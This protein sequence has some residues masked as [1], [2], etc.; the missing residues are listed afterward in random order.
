MRGSTA[1]AVASYPGE[2]KAAVIED[3]DRLLDSASFVGPIPALI[4][5]ATSAVIR[6]ARMA[7]RM[8]GVFRREVPEY[9]LAAVRE[10]IT[11]ALMHRDYSP[12]ACG[13]QVQVNL[14]TDRLEILNPGGL[15]GAVALA[16]LGSP[17][18]SSARNQHPRSL[19]RPG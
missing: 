2:S 8:N 13:T 19:R 3:G 18:L 6:N 15:F 5:D 4:R 14:F 12:L 9:P 17:G 7:G 16:K 10:A 11:N 1:A